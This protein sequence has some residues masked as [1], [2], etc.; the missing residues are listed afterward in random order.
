MD[1]EH[2]WSKFSCF[3]NKDN[4]EQTK[5]LIVKVAIHYLV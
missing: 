4:D 1:N 2:I 5:M 3:V